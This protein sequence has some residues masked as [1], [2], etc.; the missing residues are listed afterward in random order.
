MSRKFYSLIWPHHADVLRLARFLSRDSAVADDLAQETLLKAFRSMDSLA[1]GTSVKPWLLVILRN[2]WTDRLRAMRR[3]E[4]AVESLADDTEIAEPPHRE[5]AD[6]GDDPQAL[7]EAFSDQQIIV[8]LQ[9]LPEAIRWT[10]LL[11]DVQGLSVQETADTLAV[12]TGTI[13]SRAHRGRAM[14]RNLL[15]PVARDLRLVSGGGNG[16]LPIEPQATE[17]S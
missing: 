10:L 13:K 15:L 1:S 2:T 14:L 6:F 7:L 11:L 3:G 4:S 12:P 8:A 9:A 5:F 17:E 16:V